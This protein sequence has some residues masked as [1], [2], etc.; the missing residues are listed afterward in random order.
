MARYA[1]FMCSDI[2]LMVH[3]AMDPQ[4]MIS[5]P[6]LKCDRQL[7]PKVKMHRVDINDLKPDKFLLPPVPHTKKEAW[8]IKRWEAAALVNTSGR[9]FNSI[10][11]DHNQGCS[12][13]GKGGHNIRYC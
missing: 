12:D 5:S 11:S 3:V 8:Q 13:C 6:S 9:R 2:A 4:I 10:Q 7:T 1:N